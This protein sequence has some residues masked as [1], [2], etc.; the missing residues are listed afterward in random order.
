MTDDEEAKARLA[1]KHAMEQEFKSLVE[2]VRVS[3]ADPFRIRIAIRT[4][5]SLLDAMA[6]DL[7]RDLLDESAFIPKPGLTA[8]TP[9]ER[10][11][12]DEERYSIRENGTPG[13]DQMK[14]GLR[15]NVRFA[16]AIYQ[17]VTGASYAVDYN[18][19]GWLAL[20]RTVEKRDAITHP[21]RDTDWAVTTDNLWDALDA[22]LWFGTQSTEL[23]KAASP[24]YKA[25]LEAPKTWPPVPEAPKEPPTD[26]A[27]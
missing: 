17:K 1:F 21:R 2:L 6:W 7:K 23:L 19:P 22:V 5:G 16:F 26:S 9:A 27:P 20:V 8:L 12:V 25:L 18:A 14:P 13:V 10:A 15:G 24:V 11:C 3:P 4:A